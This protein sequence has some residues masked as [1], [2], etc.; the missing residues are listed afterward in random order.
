MNDRPS[1]SPQTERLQFRQPH[2]PH[3]VTVQRAA[4]KDLHVIEKSGYRRFVATDGSSNDLPVDLPFGERLPSAHPT[5]WAT[6]YQMTWRSY[7]AR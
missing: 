3:N 5:A 4:A 2:S 6:A 7:G 1:N